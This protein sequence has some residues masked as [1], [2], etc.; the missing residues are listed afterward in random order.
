MHPWWSFRTGFPP[1]VAGALGLVVMV[2]LL[3]ARRRGI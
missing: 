3:R 1:P 2:V